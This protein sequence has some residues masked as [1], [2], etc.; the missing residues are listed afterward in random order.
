MERVVIRAY[1][2]ERYYLRDLPIHHSQQ[3]I[4]EGEDYSDFELKLRPTYD[5]TCY[6]VGLGSSVQVLSPDWLANE[7]RDMH[8][9]AAMM[10]R[11]HS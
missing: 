5:F 10:Y 11:I 8:M 3:E 1:G 9:D 6:L 7:V 2:Q 4:E